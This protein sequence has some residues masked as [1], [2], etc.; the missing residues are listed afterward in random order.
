MRKNNGLDVTDRIIVDFD[1]ERKLENYLVNFEHYIKNE[2][3]ADTLSKSNGNEGLN[4]EIIIGEFKCT[5]TVKKV[6]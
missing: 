4:E 5:I 1:C 6:V 2:I 3:L